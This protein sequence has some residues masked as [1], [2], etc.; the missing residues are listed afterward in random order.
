MQLVQMMTKKAFEELACPMYGCVF[1]Y[2][3]FVYACIFVKP[4]I[5]KLRKSKDWIS[6]PVWTEIR[7]YEA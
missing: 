3:V 4:M 2:F 6:N 7:N 5:I 1:Y